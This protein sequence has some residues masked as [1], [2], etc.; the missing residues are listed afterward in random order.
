MKATYTRYNARDFIQ[1]YVDT[2]GWLLRDEGSRKFV[3]IT[4][5]E[6]G[7]LYYE[8][9]GT[10]EYYATQDRGQVFEF[11]PVKKGWFN[12]SNGEAVLLSRVPAR[13]WKRGIS[14]SNTD[15]RRLVNGEF[16]LQRFVDYKEL[17]SIFNDDFNKNN[18]PAKFDIGAIS[19]HFCIDKNNQ[20]WFYDSNV[21][22]LEADTFILD[23]NIIEQELR[24][25]IKRRGWKFNVQYNR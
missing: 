22:K 18:Y 15:I 3:H 16:L 8:T 11:I 10:S 19:K 14:G 17:S 24:D 7:R 21:G 12:T 13:Q 5:A 20:L 2:Y 6:E 1:R 23:N 25:L 9:D 4:R